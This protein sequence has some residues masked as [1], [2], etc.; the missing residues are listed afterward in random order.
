MKRSEVIAEL[1]LLNNLIGYKCGLEEV[2]AAVDNS[3]SDSTDLVHALDAAVLVAHKSLDYSLHSKLVVGH[4]DLSLIGNTLYKLLV[5]DLAVD[6]D[7]LAVTLCK[8]VFVLHI[9]K[10]I[11]KRTTSC[12]DYEN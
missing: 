6:A 10:L 12:V 1:Q 5:R 8:Y 7:T 4:I 3:V 2:G 9:K 11:L